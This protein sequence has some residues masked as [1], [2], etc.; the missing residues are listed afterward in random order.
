MTQQAHQ[1][2][3]YPV[4]LQRQNKAKGYCEFTRTLLHYEKT[5]SENPGENW[6]PASHADTCLL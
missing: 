1:T 4:H 3:P 6:Y 2:V 5:Y